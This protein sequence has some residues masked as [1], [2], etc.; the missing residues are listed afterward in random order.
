MKRKNTT[1]KFIAWI[2]IGL[3]FT[4]SLIFRLINIDFTTGEIEEN[5]KLIWI[6]LI[7]VSVGT[8]ILYSWNDL[9]FNFKRTIIFALGITLSTALI[10]V[11]NF[12]SSFCA[13]TF[14]ETIYSN[15]NEKLEIKRRVLNCGA[16]DSDPSNEMVKTYSLGKYLIWNSAI[17]K[18]DINKNEWR[19]E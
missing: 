3:W 11:I 1:L 14:S 9:K 5:F 12:F 13:L 6:V 8:L 15:K 18:E 17:E 10:I 2:I 19:K 7:P 16:G 4:R